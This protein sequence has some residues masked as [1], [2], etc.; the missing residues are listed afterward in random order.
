MALGPQ[1]G[2]MGRARVGRHARAFVQALA[3][4]AK[5]RSWAAVQR[6]PWPMPTLVARSCKGRG[7]RQFHKPQCLDVC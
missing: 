5:S 1:S 3:T 4:S 2:K 6:M 7:I